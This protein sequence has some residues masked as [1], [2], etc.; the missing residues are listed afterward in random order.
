MMTEPA[1]PGWLARTLKWVGVVTAVISL[2]LGVRQLTSW[3]GDVYGR[4][5]EA[6]TLIDVARQQASRREFAAAW[7]SLDRAEK[8]RAG[9]T[10]DRARVEIAFAWLQDARPGPGQRFAVITD[11]VTPALDRALVSAEDERRADL[12]AHLGWATFLRMRDGHEGDPAPSYQEALAIDPDNVFANAMLGHWL[13]WRSAG[14]MEAAR[15]HF[16]RA[17]AAAG[18]RRPY[19]RQLQLA[20]LRN[21][22]EA[23]DAE[24]LRVANEMRMRNERL[25]AN[26]A[27]YMFWIFTMRYGPH[28][29][30]TSRVGTVSDPELAATYDWV[31]EAS[32]SA[33]RSGAR[34]SVRAAL[35]GR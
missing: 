12:L 3:I 35:A 19:V 29:P 6:A 8:A 31:V 28:A 26:V 18:D 17:L 21:R 20:A 33:Q 11:A 14:Q 27:D 30:R 22:N 9:E 15:E 7:T 16:D 5:R 25:D 13:L 23:G 2:L 24:L 32:P 34:E 1:I 4:Q 10:V